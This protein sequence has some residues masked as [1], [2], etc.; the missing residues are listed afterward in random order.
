MN[1]FSVAGRKLMLVQGDITRERA[2]AIVNAANSSLMGGGGVDGAIHAAGGPGILDECRLIRS[3]K[4]DLPT[5]RAV[6]TNAGRL[7]ALKVIHT[8]GPIW[9]GGKRGEPELLAS[10]Y[11]SS[12]KLATE[13]GLRTIAFPSIS[14]GSYRFPIKEAAPIALRTVIE[15]MRHLDL[16]EVRFVLFTKTDFDVYAKT[17]AEIA[18][19]S[20]LE[21]PA[22]RPNDI[23]N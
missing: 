16:D 21:A 6:I 3:R 11:R 22:D 17:L 8:A 7:P 5:G 20:S 15:E 9:S 13:H 10:C 19:E 23:R 18:R 1:E 2:C 14:T 12:L 4:G